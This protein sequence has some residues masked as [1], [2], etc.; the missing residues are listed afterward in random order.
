MYSS[1]YVLQIEHEEKL[2]LNSLDNF[3]SKTQVLNTA[4]AISVV[5]Y[6]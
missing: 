4:K 2:E 1:C 5:L 3:Q 6:K